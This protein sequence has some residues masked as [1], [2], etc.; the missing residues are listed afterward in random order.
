MPSRDQSPRRPPH[1]KERTRT[2]NCFIG[3][4]PTQVAP[5]IGAPVS[6]RTIRRCLT[7]GHFGSGRPLRLLPL[8]PTHRRLSL[9]CRNARGNW[10]ATE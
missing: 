2:A 1:H 6:S 4:H 10:T 9:E 8:T 3:S 7:E 5:S